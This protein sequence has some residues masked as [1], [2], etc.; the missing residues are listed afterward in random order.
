MST[1]TSSPN[2]QISWKDIPRARRIAIKEYLKTLSLNMRIYREASRKLRS[3]IDRKE[4]PKALMLPGFSKHPLAEWMEIPDGPHKGLRF[5]ALN[6]DKFCQSFSPY[7]MERA[8][9]TYRHLHVA[10]SMARGKSLEQIEPPSKD[11]C[12]RASTPARDP[13]TL[14][15]AQSVLEGSAKLYVIVR[16]EL[17]SGQRTAQAVHAVQA[18]TEKYPYCPW[19]NGTIIIKAAD[20]KEDARRKRSFESLVGAA[21]TCEMYATYTDSDLPA[22]MSPSAFVCYGPS[23][24]VSGRFHMWHLKDFPLA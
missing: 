7:D 3:A 14:K 10:C 20:Y 21:S 9:N 17:T 8:Y 15:W 18:F 6:A 4:D 19:Q 11:G 5:K 2:T 12:R 23:T 13:A 24:D 16:P 22:E 1:E